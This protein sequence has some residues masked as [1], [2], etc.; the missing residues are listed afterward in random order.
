M[1]ILW[2]D[3]LL[4]NDDFSKN[5]PVEKKSENVINVDNSI[6]E[7]IKK[8]T[9]LNIDLNSDSNIDRTSFASSN[10]R[11]L[12]LD[13]ILNVRINNTFATAD[14]NLLK[15]ENKN[16]DLLKDYSFDTKIGY[17]VNSLLDSTIRVVGSDSMIISFSSDGLVEENLSHLVELNE[18]YNKITN[19]NK[20]IAIVS[21][22]E[23]DKLKN[24]YIDHLKNNIKYSIKKEPDVVLEENK[25]DDIIVNSAISLFGEDIVEVE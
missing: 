2:P 6:S 12:N 11:I 25:N 20:N 16:F 21:D 7:E 5:E 8:D 23:W 15:L 3:I 4:N 24:D 1:L 19:S 13:E 22:S 10:P 18:V 9:V 14:K 17:L